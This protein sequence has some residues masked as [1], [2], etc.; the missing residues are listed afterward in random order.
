MTA[1]ARSTCARLDAVRGDDGGVNAG[2][3]VLALRDVSVRFGRR[4]VLSEVTVALQRGEVVG[5]RGANGSGKTTLLR[6]LAGVLRPSSGVRVQRPSVAFV[7]AAVMPPPVSAE[8]WLVGVRRHRSGW[9]DALEQLCFDGDRSAPCRVLSLGNFRKVLLA[10][11]L[12]SG[13]D[14]VL[15]DE[16]TVGLD[17]RGRAGV[18]TLVEAARSAGTAIVQSE[19]DAEPIPLATRTWRASN[20]TVH[21]TTDDVSVTAAFIGPRDRLA[22]LI[23]AARQVGFV[24][25]EQER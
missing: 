21:E 16:A 24:P 4:T 2:D 23:D 25:D 10:D 12:T 15:L 19:Q 5:L 7:P 9:S 6:V 8:H 22:R 13:A 14:V 1:V 20:R 3:D 11:A 18:I 17:D